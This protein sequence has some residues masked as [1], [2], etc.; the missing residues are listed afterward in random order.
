[1]QVLGG[2]VVEGEESIFVQKEFS[3]HIANPNP[4]AFLGTIELEFFDGFFFIRV[5]VKIRKMTL[6]GRIDKPYI[7]KWEASLTSCLAHASDAKALKRGVRKKTVFC[8]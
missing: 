7:Y 8:R 1:M 2:D 3:K 6:L 5:L 4:D